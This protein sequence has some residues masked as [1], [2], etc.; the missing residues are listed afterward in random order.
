MLRAYFTSEYVVKEG[1]PGNAGSLSFALRAARKVSSVAKSIDGSGVR[2]F[3][4]SP[5]IPLRIYD[6]AVR[7]IFTPRRISAPL[8]RAWRKTVKQRQLSL[9]PE[10]IGT[11][12][13]NRI[14]PNG[15][16]W[17][18]SAVFTNAHR[19]SVQPARYTA[20]YRNNIA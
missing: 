5:E 18:C 4:A 7:D 1:K 11:L 2:P 3:P 10:D 12:V 14:R 6:F 20:I 17:K 13:P 15:K 8:S 9:S 19:I 16:T